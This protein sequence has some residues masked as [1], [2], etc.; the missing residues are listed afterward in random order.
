MA[1]KPEEVSSIIAQEIGKYES[2]LEMESV[3]TVRTALKRLWGDSRC[4]GHF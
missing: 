2:R 3:G 1:L 4:S